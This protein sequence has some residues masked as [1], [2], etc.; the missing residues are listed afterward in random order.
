MAEVNGKMVTCDR[1]GESIFLACT[2]EGER[3]GGFTRWTKFEPLPKGWEVHEVPGDKYLKTCP[4]CSALWC[5]VLT[6]HFINK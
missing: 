1:C 2:G 5:E 4:S 6:E 3:D